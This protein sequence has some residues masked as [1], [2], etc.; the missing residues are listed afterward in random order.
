MLSFDSLRFRLFKTYRPE[1]VPQKIDT[2]NIQSIWKPLPMSL[3]EGLKATKHRT[4]FR[5]EGGT[6]QNWHE[7]VTNQ[8]SCIYFDNLLNWQDTEDV[9]TFQVLGSQKTKME[10]LIPPL[11]YF[12]IHSEI[13]EERNKKLKDLDR[14]EDLAKFHAQLTL[15]KRPISLLNNAI[16]FHVLTYSDIDYQRQLIFGLFNR[17]QKGISSSNI[18]NINV[19]YKIQVN[20]S[21]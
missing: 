1:L 19:M 7:D 5:F 10:P 2:I 17:L 4:E 20:W 8:L 12:Q 15:P 21:V 16:G 11:V 13:F 14:F 9:G 3:E 18:C 6:L